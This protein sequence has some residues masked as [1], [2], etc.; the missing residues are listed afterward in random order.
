MT[1]IGRL[2]RR[3]IDLTNQ[4]KLHWKRALIFNAHECVYNG[5]KILTE[6]FQNDRPYISIDHAVAQGYG[7]GIEELNEAIN[8][9]YE[10]LGLYGYSFEEKKC[11]KETENIRKQ[12]AGK[13]SKLFR[14]QARRIFKELRKLP[15][16]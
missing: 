15:N 12:E 1:D 14:F 3:L 2:M 4:N 13:T 9:Q 5:I 10:H 6:V 11:A 16:P 7:L 8:S